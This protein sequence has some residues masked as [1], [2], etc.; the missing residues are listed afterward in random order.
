MSGL[1]KALQLSLEYA[2]ERLVEAEAR[3]RRGE[4][5]RL[6]GHRSYETDI[7]VWSLHVMVLEKKLQQAL[8]AAG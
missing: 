1:I 2:Q 3:A 7:S 4:G 8:S 5:G 6:F